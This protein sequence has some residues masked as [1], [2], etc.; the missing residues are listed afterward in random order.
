MSVLL[1]EAR[2]CRQRL[3][4]FLLE[5]TSMDVKSLDKIQEKFVRRTSQAGPDY[6]A[7]VSSPKR[8]WATATKAAEP[9]YDQAIAASV[10]QKR[11]GKGVTRAGT[12]KFIRAGAGDYTAGFQ[13]FHSALSSLTLPPRKARRDPSN[14][15]RVNA[16]VQAMIRTAE[17]K[18]G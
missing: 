18:G 12:A 6:D 15:Q 4:V 5:V 13:P 16:V 8:D 2:N 14:L 10:A 17:S 1:R 9:N 11:F 3:R 7:G